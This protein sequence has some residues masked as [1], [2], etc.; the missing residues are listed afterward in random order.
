M[1][2]QKRLS[3][4]FLIE[5]ELIIK[6]GAKFNSANTFCKEDAKENIKKRNSGATNAER[7]CYN[8][9][10]FSSKSNQFLSI[11]TNLLTSFPI[12]KK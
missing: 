8:T 9:L 10:V 1:E 12:F 3:F 11:L 5:E 2:R 7:C 6:G 4:N